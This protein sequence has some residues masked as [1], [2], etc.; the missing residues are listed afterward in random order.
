MEAKLMKVENSEAYIEITVDETAVEQGMN[1]AYKK[2]VKK[3]NVP[4][5][6]KG[7]AP[8]A[9]LTAHYGKEIFYSD[10]LEVI[11]PD[12]YEKALTQLDITPIAQ[13]EF[14]FPE[15]DIIDKTFSFSARVPVKP[16]V[17]LGKIE[18]IDVTIPKL[19]LLEGDI[20]NA[21]NDI[22][23]RYALL[24]ERAEDE[25]AE[26]NDKVNID[27]E[28]FVNDEPFEGGKADGYTLVL[29][30]NSFIPGFEDQLIGLRKGEKKDLEVYFPPK[31][32][33]QELADK[34]A[35]FK[36]TLNKIEHKQLRELNDEFAQEVSEFDT[37][38]E[39]RADV[40]EKAE[41][42]LTA[43]KREMIKSEVLK[44]AVDDCEM[45]LPDAVV[46]ER[47]KKML[48]Q[49]QQSMALQGI[50]LEQY[51]EFSN[52]SE[53]E[54]YKNVWP[55]A[56]LN[57]RTDFMLEKIAEEKGFEADDEELEKYVNDIAGEANIPADTAKEILAS[58]TDNVRM[59]ICINKAIDYLVEN[60]VVTE[61]EI[62]SEEGALEPDVKTGE[63]LV[64]TEMKSSE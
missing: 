45:I 14:D 26:Y 54:F 60:A 53:E 19:E 49:L 13:P 32:H 23:G 58:S 37:L 28:G 42:Q 39:M 1:Q 63:T 44:K 21:L 18:E 10:A 56:E 30:S 51:F 33:N 16:E 15:D 20:E 48:Q 59:S 35:V 6:R 34:K 55:E 57:V 27:F 24:A 52:S 25:P 4:G 29:G 38:E 22:Q 31:Y 43:R 36:V 50:T 9:I 64:E 2:I 46:D 17:T 61:E 7:K 41:Q 8:R 47:T 5:F 11:V 62:P 3:L 12:A 40:R